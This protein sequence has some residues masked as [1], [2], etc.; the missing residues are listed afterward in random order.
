M[1][2]V[3]FDLLDQYKGIYLGVS[4]LVETL[5]D[6]LFTFEIEGKREIRTSRWMMLD[7]NQNYRTRNN[8]HI[9]QYHQK[10]GEATIKI[11]T[12]SCIPSAQYEN[13]PILAIRTYTAPYTAVVNLAYYFHY[14][15]HRCNLAQDTEQ[16]G[17][18]HV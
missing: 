5:Q 18:A 12:N 10:H 6:D 3:P 1:K 14:G 16:I 9:I 17:R 13:T 8:D 7:V 15:S 2:D 11:G 4:P